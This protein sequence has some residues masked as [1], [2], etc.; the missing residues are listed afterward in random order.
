L[1]SCLL[2]AAVNVSRSCSAISSGGQRNVS[3]ASSGDQKRPEHTFPSCQV[4]QLPGSS[5][6]TS[7]NN[8]AG[9]TV[10]SNVSSWSSPRGS[11]LAADPPA[12]RMHFPSEPKY[13]LPLRTL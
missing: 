6:F 8:V 5:F 13:K 11:T 9:A 10:H 2:T 3:T 7:S 4:S 1:A 12:A